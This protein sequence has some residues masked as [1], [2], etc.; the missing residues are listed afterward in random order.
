MKQFLT[1]ICVVC[2]AAGSARAEGA[3]V[4][5]LLSLQGYLRT[6]G[7]QAAPGGSKK[8]C[9]ELYA[10]QAGGGWLYQ[11]LISVDT[12]GGRFAAT[13]GAGGS[14][15]GGYAELGELLNQ[16]T[17][18]YL[19]LH[20]DGC[21]EPE[22][23]GR[24]AVNSGAF[25]VRAG[26]AQRADGLSLACQPGQIL[27]YDGAS[28]VCG[29]DQDT[30][31]T[32]TAGTGLKLDGGEFTVDVAWADAAYVPRG[33]AASVTGPMLAP[34]AVDLAHL[35]A[36]CEEGEV[37]AYASGAWACR[38]L[39]AV[40]A[41]DE[42]VHARRLPEIAL[43]VLS[44][45]YDRTVSLPEPV[46]LADL[47]TKS[48]QLTTPEN[49]ILLGASATVTFVH[50][51]P[52][53][54]Q[55]TLTYASDGIK[56]VFKMQEGVT[57][58][59]DCPPSLPGDP[60]ACGSD[61]LP[62]G[63]VIHTLD[64]PVGGDWSWFSASEPP[65]GATWTLAVSDGCDTY[66]GDW[67]GLPN[68][69]AT[70]YLSSFQIAYR[71]ASSEEL[72]VWGSQDVKGDLAVTGSASA[73]SGSFDE[74]SAG[75]LTALGIDVGSGEVKAGSATLSGS[76]TAASATLS[77]GI[78]AKSGSFAGDLSVV[79]GVLSA[80]FGG[81][82]LDAYGGDIYLWGVDGGAHLPHI[83]W[84]QGDGQRAMYLGYGDTTAKYLDAYLENGYDLAIR[85]GNVGI[86]TTDPKAALHVA[87]NAQVDDALG[88]GGALTVGGQPVFDATGTLNQAQYDK[89]AQVRV[90]TNT[91][92]TPDHDMHLNHPNRADSRTYLY[93]E[94]YVSGSLTASGA[95]N[96]A[97]VAAPSG[98]FDELKT[99]TLDASGI[100]VGSGEVKA[101]SATLSGSLTAASA[102]LSGGIQAKSG[103]FAG[104]LSVVDGELFAMWNGSTLT[105]LGGDIVLS[106]V[107][108]GAH[109][110]HVQWL[111]GDGKRAM[112]LG[113]G[114]T[115]AKYLEA[116]L[117][118]GY[119]LSIRGGKVGIGTTDPQAPLHVVGGAQ[120]DG[121]LGV[122][123]VITA[124]GRIDANGGLTI[125]EGKQLK[126]AH[127]DNDSAFLSQVTGAGDNQID[128]RLSLGDDKSD[129]ERFSIYSGPNCCGLKEEDMHY[130]T[131]AGNAFHRGS[132]TVGGS[133]TGSG[134]QYAQHYR[135]G[136][137]S[138]ARD[139]AVD[140]GRAYMMT[141]QTNCAN[142]CTGKEGGACVGLILLDGDGFHTA[143]ADCTF[144]PTSGYFGTAENQPS[145]YCC[146]R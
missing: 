26:R 47:E 48:F 49:G 32:Y 34:G 73:A 131:A 36:A 30:D 101:G 7:G 71:L 29:D 40:F 132:L 141:S 9:V 80:S 81:S 27:A 44:N 64:K 140:Y 99:G 110:P 83:N 31:T 37:F 118:N 63:C 129:G 2:G 124:S 123:G 94:P 119:D 69:D 45:Q 20:L 126:F 53:A 146:C 111:Q 58:F 39:G 72:T 70:Q 92:G 142:G 3:E 74:L 28:W 60:L 56:Q 125:G 139:S 41:T 117:E 97:S 55:V 66:P 107:N 88:V 68:G 42:E 84:Y 6:G 134:T 98:S 106:G 17:A 46:A 79:D 128:I 136:P 95:L 5:G 133:L 122:G 19:A 144:T 85:G 116:Y 62:E 89:Q 145:V 11:E 121:A 75:M 15:G 100:D 112:Y 22:L 1:A 16:Q 10:T 51:H 96:A 4:P 130:F 14:F 18:L 113:Y 109:L 137:N 135:A 78:E 52:Q 13:I 23:G 54:L 57:S 8:L 90:L 33:E 143:R 114:D 138:G 127:N 25:A 21:A 59:G 87:G 67:S 12:K 61:P 77:G 108:G 105:A 120:V 86:G 82:K 65:A 24:Q 76:L 50:P 115:T 91:I 104:D 35:G 93:N 43:G 102:T 38:E 103:S